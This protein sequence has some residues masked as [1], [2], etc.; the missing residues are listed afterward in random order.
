MLRSQH[1]S[2]HC[3]YTSSLAFG[4]AMTSLMKVLSVIVLVPVAHTTLDVN[5]RIVRN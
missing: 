3:G 1:M 5:V 2:K 4:L